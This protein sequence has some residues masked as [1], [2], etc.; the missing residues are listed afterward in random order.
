[1]IIHHV[2]PP[3]RPPPSS[4]NME[5]KKQNCHFKFFLPPMS[6]SSLRKGKR[7]EFSVSYA[8]NRSRYRRPSQPLIPDRIYHPHALPS[9]CVILT[10][11]SASMQLLPTSKPCRVS[12]LFNAWPSKRCRLSKSGHPAP[13]TPPHRQTHCGCLHKTKVVRLIQE[14]DL[15][16]KKTTKQSKHFFCLLLH[17]FLHCC[18]LMVFPCKQIIRT[19]PWTVCRW[20]T[21]QTSGATSTPALG[22]SRVARGGSTPTRSPVACLPP[23]R[24]QVPRMFAMC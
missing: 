3:V 8:S 12:L 1:M 13:Q 7:K 17:I 22:P 15:L 11:I 16:R 9:Q 2:S 4:I 10:R 18:M 5:W 14:Y 6:P 19:R 23:P 24:N 21:P 20:W